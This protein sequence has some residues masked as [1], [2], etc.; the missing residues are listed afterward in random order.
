MKSSG[1]HSQT[2]KKTIKK[3]HL[4]IVGEILF[5][6]INFYIYTHY[7]SFQLCESKEQVN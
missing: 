3:L 7:I 6:Y 1:L 2:W 5:K 4:Q